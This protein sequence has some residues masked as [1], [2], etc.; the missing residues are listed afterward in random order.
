M[1][2]EE[3]K[4]GQFFLNFVINKVVTKRVVSVCWKKE[5]KTEFS[6]RVMETKKEKNED[7]TFTGKIYR[8]DVVSDKYSVN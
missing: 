3:S 8:W 6:E 4:N 2:H 7:T 1:C 5:I